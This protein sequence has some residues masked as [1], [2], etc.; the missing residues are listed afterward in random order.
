M[1]ESMDWDDLRVFLAVSRAGSLS[2]AARAL[3]V[4]HSTVFRRLNGLEPKLDVRLFDRL[5]GGYALTAAGDTLN[6]AAIRVEEEMIA[7][8]RRLAGGDV[9]PRGVLRVTM[10]DSLAFMLLPDLLADFHRRYPEIELELVVANA[11]LNLSRRDADVALRPTNTPPEVLV[12]RRLASIATAIYAAPELA[13]GLGVDLADAPWVAPDDSLAHIASARW[14]AEMAP[15][16]V[17]LRCNSLMGLVAGARSGLGLAAIPC[18]MADPDPGLVRVREPVLDFETGLW[19]LTHAD[20]R[21]TGRV[22]AF[23][24]FIAGAVGES[25]G[26]LEGRS[27][28]V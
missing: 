21:R 12:G 4:N 25:R 26:V 15:P 11:F 10:P 20:L 28:A 19:A 9:R 13:G 1:Q 24:D 16:R 3:A 23:L 5:P 27:V 6:Q 7:A 14:L 2:G 8:E 18:F 17:A 22:R